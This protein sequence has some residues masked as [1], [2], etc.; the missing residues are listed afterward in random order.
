MERQTQVIDASV[1]VKW[2]AEE[3]FTKKALEIKSAL[4]SGAA[5][6]IVPEL[7]FLEVMNAL[8]YKKFEEKTLIGANE[9]L[10]NIGLKV[11]KTTGLLINKAISLAKKYN[12]TIY[13]AIYVATAQFHG[14]PF[15]TADSTLYKV[16]NVVPLENI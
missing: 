11:E 1:A 9:T 6:I 3:Q 15:V 7:I 12:L 10:W 13:D 5:G 4:V 8:R 14:A 2:F 16:P